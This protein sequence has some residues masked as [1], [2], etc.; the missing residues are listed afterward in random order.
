MK[1]KVSKYKIHVKTGDIVKIISG[2]EKG[3]FGPIIRVF[4][5]TSMVIVKDLNLKIKHQQPK[6]KGE[7]GEIRR[8]EAPIHSSNVMLYSTETKVSSRFTIQVNANKKLRILKKNNEIVKE[9]QL[10]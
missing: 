2:K 5:K 8:N 1:K 10:K 9:N 3:K 7:S 6:Q 4:P